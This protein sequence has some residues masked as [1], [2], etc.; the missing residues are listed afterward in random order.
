MKD[1]RFIGWLL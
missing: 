1:D